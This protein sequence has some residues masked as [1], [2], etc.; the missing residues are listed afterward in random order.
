MEDRLGSIIYVGKARDLRKRLAHYFTPSAQMRAERKTRALI[1]SIADFRFQTVL[2]EQEALLL[3]SKLIKQYRPRYNVSQRD[4]KRFFLIKIALNTPF[5]RLQLTRLKKDD[6]AHYFGP[7][8]H[9]SALK[10]TIGWMNK[11]FGLR[12]CRPLIPTQ[13]DY[14][15]CNADIIRSCLAPCT[16]RC[17]AQHYDAH[18][19][20]AIALLE[21]KGHK[22]HFDTLRERM[23]RCAHKE[24]FERAARLRDILE[25]LEKTL[26]PARRFT[27]TLRQAEAPGMVGSTLH[28]LKDL[29][30]LSQ[31]LGIT[32]LQTIECF[33]ISNISSTHIVASMVRFEKGI[34]V[35][36]LYR[37]YRIQTTHGQNDFASMAEVVHRRYQRLQREKGTQM[38]DLIIV[39]GGKGQLSAAKSQLDLLDL[40]NQPIVGLAKKRE[41]VFFT[42]REEPLCLPHH[43]GALKLLQRIRDEAHRFANNYNALL[44]NRRMRESL[45][46]E[47][48][49]I[50]PQRKARLLRHFGSVSRIAKARKTE[51]LAV[52]G[53]GEKTASAI[54]S[55]FHH[56]PSKGTH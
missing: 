44:L 42:H 22:K 38:P 5:P 33:D 3:E 16:E 48:A 37:R 40:S 21:G 47:I 45:L 29:Q 24:Q 52:E 30:A 28:P 35:N 39:D 20:D 14:R 4:D 36:R 31:A 34:P 19:Q 51:L 53:I 49:G 43:T 9:S 12:S 50:S 15:H 10:E 8:V 56:K 32:P 26:R 46:D 11:T 27:R 18:L 41:E 54:L 13:K 1:A 25:N 23:V 17:T 7:F 55:F 2:N 6:N